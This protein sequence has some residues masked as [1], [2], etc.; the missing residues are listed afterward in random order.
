V[1][2]GGGV[3]LDPEPPRGGVRRSSAFGRFEQLQGVPSA[4]ALW[5]REAGEDGLDAAMFVR[6][7]GLDPAEATTLAAD[8]VAR[9][10]AAGDPTRLL[11]RRLA[12]RL[13]EE[14]RLA[15]AAKEPE[16]SPEDERAGRVVEELI[17]SGGLA[18]PDATT[19]ARDAK[20]APHDLDRVLHG[21]VRERR[22]ARLDGLHFHPEALERL[23]SEVRAL[24]TGTAASI[25]VA[26]FKTRYGLSR[27]FA[28]PLL[29]WLD[30]ERVTRRMGEKRVVL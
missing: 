8:L 22:L 17:R 9:G 2:I 23:K 3:V 27:K 24:K 28:I 4:A 6:R 11:E 14:A 1:T 13:A 25:D 10:V 20:L 19:L 5:L 26:A 29:E 15:Q 12:E 30:R 16:R 7:G 18:P 21:L